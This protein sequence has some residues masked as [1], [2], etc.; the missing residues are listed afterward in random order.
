MPE[1]SQIAGDNTDALK[2]LPFRIFLASPGD[3]A[4]EREH[5]RSVIESV[6]MEREFRNN[7]KPECIAWDRPGMAVSMQATGNPLP[8][9]M[10][11]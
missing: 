6:R 5:V 4:K 8:Q 7:I 3:V 2:P 10:E 11:R 9:W 1:H